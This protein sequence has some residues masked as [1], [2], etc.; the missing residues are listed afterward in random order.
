MI[1]NNDLQTDFEILKCEAS[2]HES[3]LDYPWIIYIAD[4]ILQGSQNTQSIFSKKLK[5]KLLTENNHE[6]SVMAVKA[7]IVRFEFTNI[8]EDTKHDLTS[9][10]KYS[11]EENNTVEYFPTIEKDNDSVK[12]FLESKGLKQYR[13][14]DLGLSLESMCK[15]AP[16]SCIIS[17]F[18]RKYL[19]KLSASL[20]ICFVLSGFLQTSYF[21]FPYKR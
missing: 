8:W 6:Y 3:Y 15:S 10:T 2:N 12:Y 11:L 14:E 5:S 19:V 1:W 18:L 7:D 13:K 4:K 16:L 9:Y 21:R 20:S 17:G